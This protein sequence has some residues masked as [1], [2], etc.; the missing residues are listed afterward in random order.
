MAMKDPKERITAREAY[1]HPWLKY[2]RGELEVLPEDY[3]PIKS[4]QFMMKFP[5]I[6]SFLI[7]P[8]KF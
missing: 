5:Y 2:H 7:Y 8:F 1:D 3:P 6:T 4:K